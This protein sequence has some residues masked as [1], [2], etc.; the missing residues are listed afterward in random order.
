M[1]PIIELNGCKIWDIDFGYAVTRKT[2]IGD[3]ARV[4]TLCVT[5]NFFLAIRKTGFIL[6]EQGVLLALVNHRRMRHEIV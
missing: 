3:E 4:E 5:D 6:M 1:R 2:G